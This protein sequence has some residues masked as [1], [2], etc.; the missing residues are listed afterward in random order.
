[1]RASYLDK[2]K[3]DIA[4]KW[5]ESSVMMANE[6]PPDRPPISSGSIALDFAIGIGGLPTDKVIEV[7]GGE[8]GGKT[9]LG[10]F[11][12]RNFLAA[13]PDRATL[14][15]DL[16]HKLSL[17]W[18]KKIVGEEY[19]DRVMLVWPDSAEQATDIFTKAV[20]TGNISFVLFDSIGGAPTQRVTEKSAEIG[21][22]GGNALAI[23]RFA[24]LASIYSHKYNCLVFGVNQIR[25]DMAGYNRHIV[26][27]GHGW[28]H[29]CALRI[30]LKKGRNKVE[31]K[32]DGELVP[33]GYDVTAK[34]MKNQ[35][36]GVEGR[37]AWYWFYNV[38]TDEY[39][40]GID[41]LDEVVR[42]SE[43]TGVVER[44]GAWYYHEGL[45]DGKIQSREKLTNYVRDHEAFKNQLV[46][47][48]MDL[49][50]AGKFERTVAPI[51]DID[52]EED[53]PIKSN[54]LNREQPDAV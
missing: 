43:V 33:V 52:A 20:G 6:T 4:T 8:S 34:I 9:T 29:A 21:N 32:I 44:K 12:M 36:G 39:G 38:P 1:M 2:L 50:K 28:V 25:D 19:M 18:V 26:P 24:Q 53:A 3:A 27:G 14:I 45:P 40:F 46:G 41:Q 10:L 22:V 49:L 15:L 42:L 37:T 7:A 54:F 16:E 48:T 51:V 11:A 13:Q 5:G 17:P 35:L 23:T 31:R 47:D 30:K